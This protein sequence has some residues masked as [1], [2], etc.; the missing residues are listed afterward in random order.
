MA[1]KRTLPKVETGY[2]LGAD[3]YGYFSIIQPEDRTINYIKNPVFYADD[4]HWSYLARGT[5][6]TPCDYGYAYVNATGE[7][8][9]RD[10]SIYAAGAKITPTDASQN[11]C[12][13]YYP[14]TLPAGTYTASVYYSGGSDHEF[15]L[16]VTNTTRTV[17]YGEAARNFG[18]G[19]NSFQRIGVTFTIP[20][21][22]NL[23]IRFSEFADSLGKL[24]PFYTDMW[25]C[26]DKPYMTHHFMGHSHFLSTYGDEVPGAYRWWGV[27]H[28]SESVRT[29][30]AYDSGKIIDLSELGFKL[31]GIVGLGTNPINTIVTPIASGGGVYEGSTDA[32]RTFTLIGRFYGKDLQDILTKRRDLYELIRPSGRNTY[33]Q[34]TTLM[35]RIWDCSRSNWTGQPLLIFCRYVSGL[36][37]AIDSETSEDITITFICD[38]PYIYSSY[39]K[40]YDVTP[41]TLHSQLDAD[42]N[43]ISPIFMLRDSDG[44]WTQLEI[45]LA[46][47]TGLGRHGDLCIVENILPDGT[48]GYY[49]YGTFDTVIYNE[50]TVT[51]NKIFRYNKTTDTISGLGLDS[52]NYGVA[53]GEIHKVIVTPSGDAF[54][55]GSFT[56]AGNVTNTACIAKYKPGANAWSSVSSGI[57]GITYLGG[58]Y[59]PEIFDVEYAS[60]DN[61]Y[62]SGTFATIDDLGTLPLEGVARMKCSDGEWSMLP[63][64]RAPGEMGIFHPFEMRLTRLFSDIKVP[65][66]PSSMRS[67]VTGFISGT[68][69]TL[70]PPYTNGTVFWDGSET[71]YTNY[72][73][74]YYADA[75]YPMN[76]NIPAFRGV[77]DNTRGRF[78]FVD[79]NDGAIFSLQFVMP[80]H[81]KTNW[82]YDPSAD[83]YPQFD[84]VYTYPERDT[85]SVYH[86]LNPPFCRDVRFYDPTF[87]EPDEPVGWDTQPFASL[88]HSELKII[89]SRL[90][91]S[92]NFGHGLE[93]YEIG[94]GAKVPE[95][96]GVPLIWYLP[97]WK[98]DSSEFSY[99]DIFSA[100]ENAEPATYPAQSYSA[101]FDINF[102]T[103]EAFVAVNTGHI[104]PQDTG[105]NNIWAEAPAVKR[106][107]N[108]GEK[109]PMDFK[110]IGPVSLGSFTNKTTEQS[111]RMDGHYVPLYGAANVVTIPS[112]GSSLGENMHAHMLDSSDA[113][114]Y[115]APGKNIMYCSMENVTSDTKISVI[116]R[117]RY[118][119]IEKAIEYIG[120]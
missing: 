41:M 52:E 72:R 105:D 23:H 51:V 59:G 71:F 3:K 113:N 88:R 50:E 96:K 38:D 100:Q 17:Q 25:Q 54:V 101:A 118:A 80:P 81:T 37:G 77:I 74:I 63:I 106:V 108:N 64:A 67:Q 5:G 116:F 24:S 34:P 92:P 102:G 58:T 30:R 14:I 26:E 4:Q 60:D 120:G 79:G 57:T 69:G 86:R 33:D 45:Q 49:V 94:G 32:P 103:M 7:P 119:S 115:V 47:P 55:V 65:G 104:F 112:H 90:T 36:E 66:Y 8:K 6:V 61:I 76:P 83:P 82:S 12:I 27:P 19:L 43:K 39:N 98:G 73:H 29:D 16:R 117:E 15:Q 87:N 48:G 13:I 93:A 68:I 11:E 95:Y 40:Q 84:T 18:T 56:S 70:S 85:P 28:F 78:Y 46:D 53:D 9:D 10:F 62:V 1:I 75:E 110:I 20:T 31:T 111:I 2:E 44:M 99:L 91:V 35:F 22:M 109:S 114:M 21:Q 107:I 89:N 97:L 42:T